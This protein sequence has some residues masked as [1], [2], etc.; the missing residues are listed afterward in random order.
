[1]PDKS[2]RRTCYSEPMMKR[3]AGTQVRR[4]LQ[5]AVVGACCPI[6]AAYAQETSVQAPDDSEPMDEIVVIVDR[7]GNPVDIYALRF[8]ASML[9]VIREF[10]LE[11]HKQ[12]EE[13]WRLKLRSEMKRD[14]SR[15]AWGY[16]AQTEAARFRYSQA[17]H[18]PIDR[19]RP[20]TVVSIRF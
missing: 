11:Q 2:A 1:M 20:A 12:D 15:I 9:K 16:D 10:A 17:N 5:A 18:L 19:V 7:D 6:L 4:F 3:A 8:E 14:S 13:S